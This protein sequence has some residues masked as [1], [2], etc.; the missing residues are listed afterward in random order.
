[1]LRQCPFDPVHVVQ[2]YRYQRHILRCRKQNPEKA[3]DFRQCKFNAMHFFHKDK[4][5]Q[6]EE[7]CVDRARIERNRR[8]DA[9]TGPC[10]TSA[11][12]DIPIHLEENWEVGNRGGSGKMI[13][14]RR[15]DILKLKQ[16]LKEKYPNVEKT[17]GFV[18]TGGLFADTDSMYST[19]GPSRFQ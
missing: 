17:G 14:P 15:E 4:I 3:V 2:A 6:H 7:E 16:V 19:D 18:A 10:T 5:N 9:F 11:T 12:D 1:M 8:L 13:R